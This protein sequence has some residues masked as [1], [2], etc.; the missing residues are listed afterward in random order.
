MPVLP[1]NPRIQMNDDEIDSLG[2]PV[3]LRK[4]RKKLNLTDPSKV[5]RLPPYSLESEQGALGC[6]LL[7]GGREALIELIAKT[8]GISEVMY[9]LRHKTIFEMLIVMM[10]KGW[11]IDIITV[12]QVLKD[13]NQ[14]EAVGGVP[15]LASLPDCTP[16]AAN[17]GYYADVIKEKYIRRK[18][19]VACTEAVSDAFDSTEDAGSFIGK[20]E[21]SLMNLSLLRADGVRKTTKTMVHAAINEIEK[22]H[23]G[24]AEIAGLATGLKDLDK[25]TGGLINAEL[26]VLAGR[27]S[28]GKAQPLDS[29]V[30]T[31]SGFVEMREVTVGSL[32]I[33]R[34]G[35]PHRVIGVFPQGKKEV[36]KVT[37][38]DGTSCRCCDDHLWFT[39]TRNERRRRP[40]FRGSVRT[41]SEIRKTIN[42]PDGGE[43]N[44]ALPSIS[45]VH[46]ELNEKL[47]LHP[48]LVGALIG[49]GTLNCQNILF[50]KPEFDLHEKIRALIPPSDIAVDAN[51]MT[52]RIKRSTFRKNMRSETQRAISAM[53]LNVYSENRFIPKI[54]LHSTVAERISLLQGLFDTDGSIVGNSVEYSTSSE[55]LMKDVIYVVRS[56]GGICTNGS[57]RIPKF[58][59]KG[60]NKRGLKSYRIFADF[61]R[62]GIIPVSSQKHLRKIKPAK[63]SYH[64]AIR[65]ITSEGI[66][67]C[68]CI[69]IDSSDSLYLTDDFIPTHNSS[70][71][72]QILDHISTD[73][74]IPTG[75][76]SLEMPGEKLVLRAI[77]N[78]SG[79]DVSHGRKL[80]ETDFPKLT[81]A[82]NKLSKSPIHI[83]DSSNLNIMEIKARTRAMVLTEGI[84]AL[85]VDY[86]Q[87]IEAV[88]GG[89]R[90]ELIG[91]MAWMFKQLARELSIPIVILSQLAREVQKENRPP[92][93]ADLRES[94]DIEGHADTI[95]LLWKKKSD[96]DDEQTELTIS[97]YPVD[98]IVDKNRNGATG[99]CRL[100]FFP[101]ITK[102]VGSARSS[103]ESAASDYEEETRMPHNDD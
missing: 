37:L 5:D 83:D 48:W 42:R 12:Q 58:S 77:S 100:L 28:T 36:F 76:F 73:Q 54:Y 94:G 75:V 71:M 2:R 74:G 53:G 81:S 38:S 98:V 35:L 90:S 88:R 45:P 41:T 11:P 64:R 8:K 27:P 19:I 102:F 30:L 87:I 86:L 51:R 66:A 34:D 47:P 56:L 13:R 72:F 46:F 7:D 23:S 25:I 31:P 99:R 103:D 33:G 44:H 91:E 43:Q 50:T 26:T 70:L 29:K 39:Q 15:Y 96:D 60:K 14:L 63:R 40:G 20:I 92:T 79:V 84:K 59:H 17:V 52:I 101:P 68:Q 55:Q 9:D 95:I 62:T 57:G 65:S 18:A 21:T 4:G 3:D 61:S 80:Y 82:A 67:E 32:V 78:R 89:K 6:C 85:G 97:C 24:G 16:S 69:A 93:M 22:R 49:D 1:V 10:E